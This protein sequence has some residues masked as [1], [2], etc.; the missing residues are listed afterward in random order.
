MARPGAA[1]SAARSLEDRVTLSTTTSPIGGPHSSTCDYNQVPR[2][3]SLTHYSDKNGL[4]ARTTTESN[5]PLGAR[6]NHP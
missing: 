4:G 5:I 3:D 1:R 6:P 2:V